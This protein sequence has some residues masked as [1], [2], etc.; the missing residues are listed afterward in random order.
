MQTNLTTKIWKRL[1]LL[2]CPQNFLE[3]SA[4]RLQ[5]NLENIASKKDIS[6]TKLDLNGISARI[7]QPDRQPAGR[8][9]LILYLH[10]ENATVAVHFESFCCHM[11]WYKKNILASFHQTGTFSFSSLENDQLG[12]REFGFLT[13]LNDSTTMKGKCYG[14]DIFWYDWNN[15]TFRGLFHNG[16]QVFNFFYFSSQVCCTL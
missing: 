3:T 2:L 14:N 10:Q 15:S 1:L 4:K 6:T 9:D 12:F 5:L 8:P 7:L 16:T 13:K 11:V